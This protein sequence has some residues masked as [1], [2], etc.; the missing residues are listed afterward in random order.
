MLSR[1]QC[2][3]EPLNWGFLCPCLFFCII[4]LSIIE[5]GIFKF[6]TVIVDFSISLFSSARF[7]H[8]LKFAVWY[9]QIKVLMYPVD[10]LF[11]YYYYVVSLSAYDNFCCSEIFFVLCWYSQ[12]CFFIILHTPYLYCFQC[13]KGKKRGEHFF[14]NLYCNLIFVATLKCKLCSCF[15]ERGIF[16]FKKSG[17][18]HCI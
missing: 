10:W 16:N 17:L 8:T 13:S 15:V 12:Y 5:N 11:F 2:H 4:I 3:L 7:S 1:L 14:V 9:R 18:Y 6:S